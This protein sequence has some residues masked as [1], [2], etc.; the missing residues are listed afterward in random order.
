[1]NTKPLFLI[2]FILIVFLLPA[3]LSVNATTKLNV[4]VSTPTLVPLIKSAAGNHVQV[5]SI[6]PFGTDPHEYQLVPNDLEKIFNADM[7]I[8]TGHF[9]WEEELTYHVNRGTILDLHKALDGKLKLLNLPNGEVNLHEWWLSPYN[10]KLVINEVASRLAEIDGYNAKVYMS[11]AENSAKS[12]DRIVTE[13]EKTLSEKGLIGEVAICSTPIEQYLIE[14]FGM[15]CAL[16]LTEEEL[17]GV[18]PLTLE[19]ARAILAENSPKVLVLVDISEGSAGA[20]VA[21]KLA[22]ETSTHLLRLA[23]MLEDGW[24]YEALLAYNAGLISSIPHASKTSSGTD[25]I[26]SILVPMLSVVVVL[27]AI[28][29]LKLRVRR[30]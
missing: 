18:K 14:G 7:L 23:V 22:S 17:S 21:E 2:S 15:H 26:T 27:E 20:G 29:I 3:Q 28:I 11:I 19:K 25:V 30:S 12:L 16:I 1:M 9:K 10:A 8:I 6:V 13:V 4:V 5:A 24:D